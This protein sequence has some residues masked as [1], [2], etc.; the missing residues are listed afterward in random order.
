MSTFEKPWGY[1]LWWAQTERYVGKL[2]HV[3]AGHKLS[4]QYHVKK[5]ET[6]HLWGGELIL[7]LDEDGLRHSRAVLR[8]HGNMSSPTVLF[9][10]E[11][12]LRDAKL[13]EIGAG[14]SQIQRLIIARELLGKG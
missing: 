3:N 12:M 2:L 9:V 8:E 7:A 4:L 13:M 11:R 10:L 1:E 5:D 14:T 6:I